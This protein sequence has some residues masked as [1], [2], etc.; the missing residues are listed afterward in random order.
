MW[1]PGRASDWRPNRPSPGRTLSGIVWMD[2][3]QDWHFRVRGWL[4]AGHEGRTG[5]VP[6]N[7]I[8]I[9]GRCD[10]QQQPDVVQVRVY[11]F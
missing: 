8:K 1:R 5:L 10:G 2:L 4:L 7:Y 3:R 6:A 9:L 11:D